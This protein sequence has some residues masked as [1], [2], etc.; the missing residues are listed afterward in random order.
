MITFSF[1][2][3]SEVTGAALVLW[4]MALNLSGQFNSVT[5]S[6]LT[7]CNPMDCRMSGFS[8]HHQLP[9]LA[10]TDQLI[11]SVM[12]FNH[13]I[14]CHPLLLPPSIFPSI[15]SFPMSQFF[16][17]GCQSIGASASVIPMNVQDRS[18]LGWTGWIPLL[19]EELS[20]V[21]SNTT[22]QKHQFFSG[23]LSL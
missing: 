3:H 11:E 5:Q 22:V 21:F 17:A 8:V 14:L 2:R 20:R 16:P 6:S 15:G 23:Q 9:E 1:E 4:Q 13:L 18:P 19:S 12:P 7:L 10:Q